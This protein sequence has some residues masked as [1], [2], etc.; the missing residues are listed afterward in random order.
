MPSTVLGLQAMAKNKGDVGPH[1]QRAY[2]PLGK[3]DLSINNY[4]DVMN[5]ML[6]EV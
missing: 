5:T 3:T 2:G 6:R 1:P 4:L